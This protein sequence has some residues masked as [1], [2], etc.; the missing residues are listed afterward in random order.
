MAKY[1][2]IYKCRLCGET[3]ESGCAGSE[4]IALYSVIF[5]CSQ[6]GQPPCPQ[7]PSITEPHSCKDGSIGVADFQGVRKAGN[8]G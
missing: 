6:N 4:K 5:A 2:I 3:Y 7:S 1:N 8:E